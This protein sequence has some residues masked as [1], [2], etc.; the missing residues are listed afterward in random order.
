MRSFSFVHTADLHL[1][2]TFKELSE[3]DN[4]I[5]S[6]LIE[7][8]FNAFNNIIDIC[9]EKKADFLLIA[10]DIYDGAE[11]SLSQVRRPH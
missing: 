3:I 9:L 6:E 8:T 1:D 5:S 11:R 4:T 2:S 7:S 10:G